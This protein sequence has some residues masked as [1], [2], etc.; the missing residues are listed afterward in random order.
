MFYKL[1]SFIYSHIN[2]LSLL[3]ILGFCLGHF[4]TSYWL[5]YLAQEQQLITTW[6]DYFYYWIVTSST[7]GYGD[8]SPVSQAGRLIVGIYFIPFSLTMFTILLAKGGEIITTRIRRTLMGHK[9]FADLSG[10]IIL[11]T[12][13]IHR[14]KKIIELILADNNRKPR[15]ILLVTK[16]HIEHP[17]PD[18]DYVE[19]CHLDSYSDNSSLAKIAIEK[20]D[21]VIIDGMNDD[22]N[23]AN[24]VHFKNKVQPNCHITTYLVDEAKADTLREL[25]VNIEVATPKAAEQMVRAMQDHGS[26]MAMHQLLTS[27]EGQTIYVSQLC[28][29]KSVKV[30]EVEHLL[31]S[32][33]DAKFLGFASDELAT[34]MQINPG[35]EAVIHPQM[36][37]HYISKQRLAKIVF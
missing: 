14:S 30:S 8:M 1:I 3:V 12:G 6:I 28:S 21:R 36:Y 9:S 31:K 16:E 37:I 20:A 32:K 25:G 18:T 5:F 4:I 15:T 35:W 27:G 24:A 26:T 11:V 7:V 34:D 19:F 29:D 17:Y 22:E 33:H 13:H 10:H 2:K 23:F